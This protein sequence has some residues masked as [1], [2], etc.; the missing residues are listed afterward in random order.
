MTAQQRKLDELPMWDFLSHASLTFAIL[1]EQ[2]ISNFI[3]QRINETSDK[4]S[5]TTSA[6]L[7]GN[8]CA[9]FA[10]SCA[11][12]FEEWEVRLRRQ[13]ERQETPVLRRSP[14]RLRRTSVPRIESSQHIPLNRCCLGSRPSCV[15][16]RSR[17]HNTPRRAQHTWCA[18]R[19]DLSLPTAAA[20]LRNTARAE[21]RGAQGNP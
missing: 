8:A 2:S 1:N 12:A 9:S 19:W 11:R 16:M 13:E 17:S 15:A 14:W 7:S 18:L 10:R 21:A 4:C 20:A 6:A 5:N 3:A